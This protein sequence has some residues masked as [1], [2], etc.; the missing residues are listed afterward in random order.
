MCF[1]FRVDRFICTENFLE[2]ELWIIGKANDLSFKGVDF[3]IT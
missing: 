2:K 3:A 1:K